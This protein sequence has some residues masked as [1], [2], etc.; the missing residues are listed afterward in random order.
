MKLTKFH[1]YF[2]LKINISIILSNK[3]WLSLNLRKFVTK[4]MLFFIKMK[5]KLDWKTF[6]SSN[7]NYFSIIKSHKFYKNNYKYLYFFINF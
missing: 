7:K 5:I 3:L 6:S 2:H 1:D 4:I